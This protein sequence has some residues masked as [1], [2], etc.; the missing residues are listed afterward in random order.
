MCVG[1]HVHVVCLH[2][3][4]CSHTCHLGSFQKYV[5]MWQVFGSLEEIKSK[6]LCVASS[7]ACCFWVCD[8]AHR[9]PPEKSSSSVVLLQFVSV[10]LYRW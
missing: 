4:L 2:L 6:N 9:G 8:Q 10:T 3:Q 5:Y 7:F 1:V